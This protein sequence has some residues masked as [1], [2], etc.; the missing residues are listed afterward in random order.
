MHGKHFWVENSGVQVTLLPNFAPTGPE[1]WGWESVADM[2]SGMKGS[3]FKK[4]EIA[5]FYNEWC[6]PIK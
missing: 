1:K 6:V 5:Y 3:S 2:R 4:G